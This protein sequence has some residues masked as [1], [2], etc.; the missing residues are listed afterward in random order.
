MITF[1]RKHIP[2]LVAVV[3]GCG[4]F[5]GMGMAGHPFTNQ[6]EPLN[7]YQEFHGQIY[8]KER[9][10]PKDMASLLEESTKDITYGT[11]HKV[12][13]LKG[14][15][16]RYGDGTDYYTG[17]KYLERNGDYDWYFFDEITGYMVCD[18][19]LDGAVLSKDGYATSVSAFT[20][21]TLQQASTASH[22]QEIILCEMIP[23][24][25]SIV[26]S[27]DMDVTS[28]YKEDVAPCGMVSS[29]EDSALTICSSANV[30]V[31][32]DVSICGI[33]D[34]ANGISVLEEGKLTFLGTI[35]G[36][37][38]NGICALGDQTEVIVC[39]GANIT[40]ASV[41]I[42]S[43][44]ETIIE[45]QSEILN[46]EGEP[47]YVQ[48]KNSKEKTLLRNIINNLPMVVLAKTV[49]ATT[50]IYDNADHGIFQDGG[51]LTMT[52][53]RIYNN[54]TLG[55]YNVT[56][57]YGGGI[58]LK[59]EAVMNM[60]G[61]FIG[62]NKALYG[63]GIYVDD[64]CTLNVTGGTIGGLNP[65]KLE[66]TNTASN[67]NYVRENQM[68]TNGYQYAGGGGG[69]ICSRGTLNVIA[70]KTTNISHNRSEGSIG[71][72]GIL[73]MSGSAHF[74]G[75]KVVVHSNV[76][77]NSL[78]G[79]DA[80][81]LGNEDK[82]AEGGG[83]RIG[84]ENTEDVVNCV[85][86]CENVAE[87]PEVTGEVYIQD[88]IAAGDGGGVFLSSNTNHQ[89]IGKGTLHINNNQSG[90]TGGGGIKSDGGAIFLYGTSLYKNRAHNGMG[91][92]ISGAG[93]VNMETCTLYE[94]V[95][96]LAGGGVALVCSANG[97]A[98]NG[99]IHECQMYQNTSY[100]TGASLHV[101]AGATGRLQGSSNVYQNY[102]SPAVHC[103]E[104]G[105]LILG[106]S[107]IYDNDS[108]GI[109]NQGTME[110]TSTAC[111]GFSSFTMASE[112]VAAA[113]T[114]GGVYNEGALLVTDSR[115]FIVY[116]GSEHALKNTGGEVSFCDGSGSRFYGKNADSIV[117]NQGIMTTEG[118]GFFRTPIVQ[119]A[120]E[121][122]RCGIN[123]DGGTLTWRGSINGA[124]TVTDT[125]MTQMAEGQILYGL[126]NQ[127]NGTV[128][129]QTGTIEANQTGMF[130]GKDSHL[131]LTGGSCQ[132]STQYGV[133]CEA[134]GQ[135][136][137]GQE[138][139]IDTS[140]AVF[141]E[142]GCYIDINAPLSATGTIAVLDTKEHADRMPGRIMAKVSYQN[143]TGASELYDESGNERFVLRYD[144]VDTG[145]MAFLLDGSQIQGITQEQGSMLSVQ[146]IYLATDKIAEEARFTAWL[147]DRTAWLSN[148]MAGNKTD[149]TYQHFAAGD[150]GIITFSC[151][152][153]TD[154]KIHWP[155]SGAVD[156]LK[157]YDV[158]G[159]Q[160]MDASYQIADLTE[161]LSQPY[162]N[163]SYH[164]VVP[165]HTPE[166]IYTVTVIGTDIYGKEWIYTLPVKVGD[167][168]ITASFRTRIR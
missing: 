19:I 124:Y 106:T 63:G 9:I 95:A 110:V 45:T 79:N 74:S 116:G 36:Q 26:F 73:L 12:L 62:G 122:V 93:I 58:L 70:A 5:L 86:N 37:T 28:F 24:T 44:G 72:A 61:G 76:A 57:S 80:S 166:G 78:A 134:Q 117:L 32:P 139:A 130:N 14:V 1:M 109:S 31:A 157:T 87:Y 126:Y 125:G 84:I 27:K 43:Q 121:G 147:Y 65:Y 90:N 60:S 144:T 83:I 75:N 40:G 142:E 102:D 66:G 53:G 42:Y 152:N 67:G 7:T 145:T 100:T 4:C 128:Y 133:Y 97:S 150:T 82:D 49:T 149:E 119:I 41:G 30:T 131:Y 71:G 158:S 143:G 111:V 3:I 127:N 92:G 164:F 163:S 141:L 20:E 112:Y 167:W 81:V 50:A 33:V 154:V 156:E 23:T 162:E 69:G 8:D 22:C 161:F 89:F 115:N 17:W 6:E 91:G 146:D 25:E 15:Q 11:W 153:I 10:N 107:F 136:H 21:E 114:D 99:Y 108:W 59:N 51:T 160:V 123:N 18:T 165:L 56:G 96:D 159:N 29:A 77:D 148:Q 137:M 16:W 34:S 105:N 46:A 2:I 140:N 113:N 155:S 47:F 104:D 68:S 64:G 101:A 39:A 132:D 168:R 94:N 135:L 54:G 138:A 103:A 88:N 151:K 52:G 118:K 85:L 35:E 55:G 48:G 120:G 129:V 13:S 38:Q 98:A